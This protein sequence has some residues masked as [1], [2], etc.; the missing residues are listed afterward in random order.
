MKIDPRHLPLRRLL[1]AGEGLLDRLL[2]LVGAVVFAQAPE[3]FQ[4]YLQRLGGRLD[5]ARRQL[6]VFRDVASRSGLTL[7]GLAATAAASADPAVARLGGVVRDTGARVDSLATAEAA[8]RNASLF[9]RPFAFARHFDP[10]IAR[11]TLS[12]FRPALPTTLEGAAYALCGMLVL[13][14][15]YHWGVKSLVRRCRRACPPPVATP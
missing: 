11:A 5:E 7:D 6:E 13:L 12:V 10:A 9:T 2:C 8:I 15:A 4:Q 1:A 3:F 14:A